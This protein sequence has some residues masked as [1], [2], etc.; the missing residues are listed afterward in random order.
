LR[1]PNEKVEKLKPWL[2]TMA[3]RLPVIREAGILLVFCALT[4]VLTLP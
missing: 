4:A 3:N 2:L 1:I